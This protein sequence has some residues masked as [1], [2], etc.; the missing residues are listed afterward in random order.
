MTSEEAREEVRYLRFKRVQISREIEGIIKQ[1]CGQNRPNQERHY[2]LRLWQ[3]VDNSGLHRVAGY[4]C[5]LCRVQKPLEQQGNRCP[6]CNELWDEDYTSAEDVA[7]CTHC[8]FNN[9]SNPG[10]LSLLKIPRGD[11][12]YS[13]FAEF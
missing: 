1:F 6:I 2:F 7:A 3:R 4:I 5:V 12:I 9:L 11:E 13:K 8:G 10:G